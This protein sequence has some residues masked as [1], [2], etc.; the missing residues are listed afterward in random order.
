MYYSA[1]GK[2]GNKSAFAQQVR[3]PVG[4]DK[5]NDGLRAPRIK[6]ASLSNTQENAGFKVDP[7]NA[8]NK[9]AMLPGSRYYL[10]PQGD[11]LLFSS[12]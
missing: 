3:I 7:S 6:K 2:V 12:V 9:I 8:P 11:F 1:I 10:D 5:D 4:N